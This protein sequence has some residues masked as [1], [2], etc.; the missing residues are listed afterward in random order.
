MH[1]EPTSDISKNSKYFFYIAVLFVAI[2]MISNTVVVKLIQVGPLVF[3]GAFLIFP[4]SYIFGDILTEVYGFKVTRKLI[5]A[6][7]LTQILMA[8]CYWIVQVM[9]P[10]S[11]WSGQ[12]AYE[13]I[14]GVV[15][16]IV[17]ASIIAYC[18]GEFANSYI[19]SKM[20]ILMNGKHLWMRTIGST[21][22]GQLLDSSIFLLLAFAGTIPLNV[23]FSMIIIMYI[24]KVVYE[25]VLTPVTYFVVRK[26]KQAEG[27]DVYDRGI[28]YN[29]F[30]LR[31]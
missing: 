3:T 13:T 25:A 30:R 24:G 6:G 16:R 15:P 19:M 14:L 23:I 12:N 18:A 7:F 2:L 8:L 10:A 26:L 4:I 22:I 20:K 31:E 27:M 29:L 17:F 1:T 9:P 28:S 5:W 21:I 11:V